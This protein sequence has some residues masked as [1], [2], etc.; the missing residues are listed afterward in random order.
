MEPRGRAGS[1]RTAMHV[2]WS[3][4]CQLSAEINDKIKRFNQPL[5]DEYSTQ[6]VYQTHASRLPPLEPWVGSY[7]H[8]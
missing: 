2:S 1:S 4:Y 8:L 5:L 3:M 7:Y 6:E